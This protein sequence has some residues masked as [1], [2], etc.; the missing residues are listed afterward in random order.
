MEHDTTDAGA[1]QLHLCGAGLGSLV[2]LLHGFP[3]GWSTWR[4]QIAALAE[5][6]YRAVAPDQRVG[7]TDAPADP[8]QYT[9]IH[10]VGDVVA[11]LDHIGGPA[12][13]VG[14]DWGCAPAS[15]TALLRPLWCA[16]SSA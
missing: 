8:S 14:H 4:H 16:A 10:P 1:L 9:S 15:H 12:L 7:R 13:L 11:L 5:A 3:E 2:V 6:G